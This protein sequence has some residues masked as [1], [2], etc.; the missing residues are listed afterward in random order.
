[1]RCTR[2]TR[3]RSRQQYKSAWLTRAMNVSWL[4]SSSTLKHMYHIA[5]QSSH[6]DRWFGRNFMKQ[7][8]REAQSLPCKKLLGTI[9]QPSRHFKPSLCHLLCKICSMVAGSIR[10]GSQLSPIVFVR[11]ARLIDMLT[12]CRCQGP[13]AAAG[14]RSLLLEL[15]M[16][17]S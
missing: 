15:M 1:V 10:S 17:H 16:Q 8:K 9:L 5:H 3:C 2:I 11:R 6:C 13:V 4:T 12:S 14:T 7:V